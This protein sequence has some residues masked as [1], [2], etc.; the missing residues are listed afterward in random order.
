MS[1]I[2]ARQRVVTGL[3]PHDGNRRYIVPR[4]GGAAA[5]TE[6]EKP[7]Q[8]TAGIIA[9]NPGYVRGSFGTLNPDETLPASSSKRIDRVL[10]L[11]SGNALQLSLDGNSIPNNDQDA[12]REFL[13]SGVFVAGFDTV[14]VLRSDA[15]YNPSQSD[16]SQWSWVVSNIV[17]VV[18]NTYTMRLRGDI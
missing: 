3:S 6:W 18:G 16:N 13:L 14:D 10:T 12:F 8:V 7:Y 17:F 4:R 2:R 15:A 11:A 1:I 5:P 9:T